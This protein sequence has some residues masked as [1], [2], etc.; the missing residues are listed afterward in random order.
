M[1]DAPETSRA[2]R[3]NR[4]PLPPL[5]F[6]AS[7]ALGYG[8]NVLAPVAL[9]LPGL[10]KL[11]GALALG[12]GLALVLWASSTL[13]RAG[14]AILPHHAASRLVT[15]GPFAWSRNPIY[16]GECL[17]I[18]G[19]GGVEGAFAYWVAAAVFVLAMTHFAIVREEAHLGAR[20]GSE[21]QAYAARVRRWI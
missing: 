16:L 9:P 13:S 7:L 14:T 3:P 19:L 6:V 1:M 11:V 12:G 18:A 2:D 20:F 8:L 10:A 4:Y 21:W 17:L 5:I 15:T